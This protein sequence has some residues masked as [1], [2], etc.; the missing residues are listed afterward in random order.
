[1][2]W[3]PLKAV[4]F[5]IVHCADTFES[6]DIGVLDIRDWHLERGWADVGYH[7]VIRRSGVVEKG[8]PED[9]PG[10]HVRGANHISIGI[11]LVGGK[12]DGGGPEDNFTKDQYRALRGLLEE[13]KRRY[14]EARVLGHRDVPGVRKECP[15]FDVESWWADS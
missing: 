5:L 15:S 13:L 9:R 3:K 6:M 12:A 2:I 8:R 4:E 11:C 7:Y 1:M 10:A 14:P